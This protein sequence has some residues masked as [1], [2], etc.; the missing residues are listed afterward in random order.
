MKGRE[1]QTGVASYI[2]TD[3]VSAVLSW[4]AFF[5]L[6]KLFID[7]YSISQFPSFLND[8]KFIQGIIIIP[9][10]WIMLYYLTGMY[11]NIYLK[12]RVN[13]ITKTFFIS[14]IGVIVLFFTVLIDDNVKD[15]KDYYESVAILFTVHFIITIVGRLAVL[16]GAK[17]R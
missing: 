12:S 7:Q 8:S 3:Y 1:T 9:V 6:R 5:T 15:Y 2:V 11:T 10:A 14:I 4:A 17:V 13:E 16:N